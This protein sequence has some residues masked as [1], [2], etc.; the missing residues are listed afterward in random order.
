MRILMAESDLQFLAEM[1][2]ALE[3]AGHKVITASDG[4]MGWSL[5]TGPAPPALL[6]TGLH[7]G[8]GA[9]PGTA[10]GLRAHAHRPRIPVVYVPTTPE[11]AKLAHPD[12]GAVLSRPFVGA[13]LVALVHR[14]ER[15]LHGSR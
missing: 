6:I 4:W 1:K 5:L 14:L 3:K 9:P 2:P 12:H 13:H 10:L 7:L 11:L 8:T 15:D